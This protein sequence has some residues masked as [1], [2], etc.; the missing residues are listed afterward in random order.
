MAIRRE[1]HWLG[2]SRVDTTHL[3]EIE[4]AVVGDFDDLAGKIMASSKAY[5]V[6]GFTIEMGSA[7]GN[8]ATKLVLDTAGGILLH[9]TASEPGAVFVV[10]DIQPPDVLNTSNLNVTGTFTASAVNYIGIDLIKIVDPSTADL[11]KF[12]SAKTGAEF[13]QVVPLARTMQYRIVISTNDFNTL[14]NLAPVAKVT[15]N[16][17]GNVVDVTDCRQ[18]MFRL[19]TGG[20]VPNP[21]N[22]YSWSSRTENPVTSTSTVN[23]FVGGDKSIASFA[24]FF[25]AMESRLWEVGGGEHWYSATTDRDV[26]FTRDPS[27][28]FVSDNENFEWTGTNIHWKGISF[29]FGNSTAIQNTITDQTTDSPGLTDLADGQ[30][31]YVD[32]NRAIN[33]SVLT[34]AKANLSSLGTPAVPG[35][36]QILAWRVGAHVYSRGSVY[37]VGH[38]FSH[39]TSAAYGV[40]KLFS[41]TGTDAIVPAVDASGIVAAH[42]IDRDTA[43]ALAIGATTATSVVISSSLAGTNIIGGLD[44]TTGFTNSV[45]LTA[46]GNGAANGI[47]GNPGGGGTAGVEGVSSNSQHGYLG[48]SLVSDRAGVVG[49]ASSMSLSGLIPTDTGVFGAGPGSGVVGRGTSGGLGVHAL[50]NT[51]TVSVIKSDGHINM[52]GSDTPATVADK[53]LT[54]QGVL[55]AAARI[56][57]NN[58]PGSSTVNSNFNFYTI[59]FGSS[60]STVILTLNNTIGTGICTQ[61]TDFLISGSGTGSKRAVVTTVDTGGTGGRTRIIVEIANANTGT[62]PDSFDTGNGFSIAVWSFN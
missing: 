15:L 10:P 44:V 24:D 29:D 43:G 57:L 50:S 7:V 12:R 38:A 42:G 56:T 5:V 62:V 31:I 32:V 58:T 22:T 59:A 30:C 23:P 27:S 16:S 11:V 47:V 20:S 26:L 14:K 28:V 1:K 4:S 49:I 6:S 21:L 41:T 48:Y 18:M 55:R 2:G 37:E 36:R 51:N 52:S 60:P 8:P 35:S 45:A 3:R 13:A 40:V 34:A 39:A 9:G 61:I 54:P 46:T 33:A 53:V 17:S 25:Q 19:G